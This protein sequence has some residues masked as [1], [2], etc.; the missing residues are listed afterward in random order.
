MKPADLIRDAGTG[1]LSHTKLWA[2]VAYV[3]ATVSFLHLVFVCHVPPDADIWL[4]Y[5][6]VVGSHCAVSKLISM[7]YRNGRR[8]DDLDSAAYRDNPRD[9]S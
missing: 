7:R 8:P 9:L 6:G 4:I 2:N 5:L 3:T 1:Q